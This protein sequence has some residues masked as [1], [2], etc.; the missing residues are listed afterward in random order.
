MTCP[1]TE[2]ILKITG[3]LKSVPDHSCTGHAEFIPVDIKH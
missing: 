3:S 2:V 1:Q